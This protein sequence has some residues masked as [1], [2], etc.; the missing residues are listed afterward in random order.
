MKRGI[1]V[2]LVLKLRRLLASIATPSEGCEDTLC[3]YESYRSQDRGLTG[4]H[5][6]VGPDCSIYVFM[7]AVHQAC[8]EPSFG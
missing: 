6:D 1:K 8:P 4:R 5:G 2:I 3:W 7:V